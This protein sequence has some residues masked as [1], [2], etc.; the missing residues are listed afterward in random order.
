MNEY[1]CLE[2]FVIWASLDQCQIAPGQDINVKV[3][4]KMIIY[5]PCV[6]RDCHENQLDCAINKAQ[7]S[8]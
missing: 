3:E 1:I 4:E 6:D 8:S 5:N 2:W 7:V